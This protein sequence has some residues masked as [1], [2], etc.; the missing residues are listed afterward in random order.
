MN[1]QIKSSESQRLSHKKRQRA[2][3]K[4]YA[5]KKLFILLTIAFT[6]GFA[7]GI[8]VGSNKETERA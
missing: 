1:E 8:F 5:Q 3:K 7:A 2:R 6:F 4:K